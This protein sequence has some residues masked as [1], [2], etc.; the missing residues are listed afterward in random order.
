MLSLVRRLVT[1]PQRQVAAPLWSGIRAF[2]EQATSASPSGEQREIGT[3]KWFSKEK[4]Y[5]FI[6]KA[7]GVDV[8]VHFSN[9]RGTGFKTLEEGQPVEFYTAA[10][11]K[12]QEARVCATTNMRWEHVC[13]RWI[14]MDCVLLLVYYR[15]C[16]SVT[17][18]L[19]P[20]SSLPYAF[21]HPPHSYLHV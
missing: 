2:S 21:L 14:L 19:L 9:V 17:K 12:G 15:M 11:K 3:V 13:M 10:G 4:G 6:T 8:F 1:L 5:G 7:D 16:L 18:R 20:P